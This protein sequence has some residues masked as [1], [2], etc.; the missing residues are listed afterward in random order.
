MFY[1][2]AGNRIQAAYVPVLQIFQQPV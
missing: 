2:Y 1:G